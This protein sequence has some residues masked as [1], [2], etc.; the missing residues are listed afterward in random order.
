M[1]QEK[2]DAIS[3]A[4]E[5]PWGARTESQIRDAMGGGGNALAAARVVEIVKRLGLKPYHAPEPL[6][7]ITVE[8]VSLVCWMSITKGPAEGIL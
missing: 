6:P 2:V 4:L 7:P 1:E 5:A 3:N 8:E